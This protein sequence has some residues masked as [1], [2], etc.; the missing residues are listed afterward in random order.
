MNS[1]LRVSGTQVGAGSFFIFL[2]IAGT[3][4]YMIYIA[5][6]GSSNPAAAPIKVRTDVLTA[7]YRAPP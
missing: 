1:M 3:R 6:R 4:P 5:T 7:K 2:L